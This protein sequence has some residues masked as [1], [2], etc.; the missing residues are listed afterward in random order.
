M[1]IYIDVKLALNNTNSNDFVEGKIEVSS[2]IVLFI[3]KSI[4]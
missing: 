3:K 1:L 2:N 4:K